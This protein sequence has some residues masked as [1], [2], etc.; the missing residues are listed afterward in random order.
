MQD[1][2]RRAGQRF[3]EVGL[4]AVADHDPPSVEELAGYVGH[5][6][7]WVAVDGR[8]APVGYLLVDHVDGC[9]HVEQV[10]VDPAWQGAGVGRALLDQARRHAEAHRLPALTLTTFRDVPWNAPLYRHLGFRDLEEYELGRDLRALRDEESAHGLDPA[11]RTC[12]RL[13]LTDG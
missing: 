4:V 10:S 13:D 5:G 7:A 6:R 2:E 8:D 11:Q 12:M 1:I 3:R 9:A